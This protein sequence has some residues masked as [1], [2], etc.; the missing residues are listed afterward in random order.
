M[1]NTLDDIKTATAI[2]N[3]IADE[4]ARLV[5]EF[6]GE[7][8]ERGVCEAC[9]DELAFTINETDNYCSF[10]RRE[11]KCIYVINKSILSKFDRLLYNSVKHVE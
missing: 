5:D 8:I 3:Q 2:I 9:V 10:I 6:I 11:D 1:T 7:C 4:R